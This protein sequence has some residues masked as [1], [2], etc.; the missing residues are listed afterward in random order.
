ML[1]DQPLDPQPTT[2][3][4]AATAHLQQFSRS[5]S[6]LLGHMALSRRSAAFT[7]ASMR[8][9]TVYRKENRLHH[10]VVRWTEITCPPAGGATV[11]RVQVARTLTGVEPHPEESGHGIVSRKSG[12][13]LTP[14]GRC[15]V[16]ADGIGGEV[17]AHGGIAKTPAAFLDAP[18]IARRRDPSPDPSVRFAPLAGLPSPDSRLTTRTILSHNA[19]EDSSETAWQPGRW[20][21]SLPLAREGDPGGAG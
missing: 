21:A 9:F 14:K 17:R 10:A 8:R 2:T 12:L 20:S 6:A 5:V 13:M 7:P 3:L 18:D 16:A 1:G 4:I 11:S 15:G 19:E